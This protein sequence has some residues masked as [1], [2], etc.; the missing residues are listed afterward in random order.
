MHLAH[1]LLTALMCTMAFGQATDASALGLLQA[2]EAALTH[3]PAYRAA[4]FENEGAKEFEVLGRAHL[5]PVLSGNYSTQKNRADITSD[6]PL[7]GL[8]SRTE[9]RR[10]TSVSA[11][12]QLRQ[13]LYHPEGQAR[14]RQGWPRPAP[15]RRN[16]SPAART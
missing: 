12:I 14:S 3:D 11:A 2:Y 1:R 10:Y 4:Q 7:S 5:L 6:S 16:L 8:P 9:Q 13:P 15:A